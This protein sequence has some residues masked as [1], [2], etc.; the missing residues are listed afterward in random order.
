MRRRMYRFDPLRVMR[1]IYEVSVGR[2]Q[3]QSVKLLTYGIISGVMKS[4]SGRNTC[5]NIRELISVCNS[6]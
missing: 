1:L 5:T 2:Q 3:Y 6:A 4:R